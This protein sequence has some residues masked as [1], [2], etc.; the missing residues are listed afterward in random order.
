MLVIDDDRGV[1]EAMRDLL[2]SWGYAA[3]CAS[4]GS[5]AERLLATS[6]RTPDVI[7][8][9]YR[10]YGEERGPAAIAVVR[11]RY[12]QGL[13][14]IVVTADDAIPAAVESTLPVL[15]KPLDPDRLRTLLERATTERFARSG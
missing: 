9:D 6:G 15:R 1:R 2:E 10:L 13:P 11:E 4:S 7:V 12:G 5:A 3:L 14:A 8:S